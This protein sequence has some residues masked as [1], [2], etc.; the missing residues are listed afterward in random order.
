MVYLCISNL[1]Y[2]EKIDIIYNFIY[3][4]YVLYIFLNGF[5]IYYLNDRFKIKITDINLFKYDIL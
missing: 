4:F 3:F 1:L 2:R 5:I